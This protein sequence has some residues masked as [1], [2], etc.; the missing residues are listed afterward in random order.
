MLGIFLNPNGIKCIGR[1]QAFCTRPRPNHASS[2]TYTGS[3]QPLLTRDKQGKGLRHNVA[4]TPSLPSSPITRSHPLLRIFY[5][6]SFTSL[7]ISPTSPFHPHLST[8][9]FSPPQLRLLAGSQP[10]TIASHHSLTSST[11]RDSLQSLPPLPLCSSAA[12][13]TSPSPATGNKFREPLQSTQQQPS[14]F[15]GPSS[16]PSVPSVGTPF[17]NLCGVP[18]SAV[19]FKSVIGPACQATTITLPHFPQFP[20]P[21][22]ISAPSAANQTSPSPATGNKFREP[23]QST[24]QQPSSLRVRLPLLP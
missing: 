7:P 1:C 12:N 18:A 3:E 17:W 15:S 4:E 24:Q 22:S 20:R 23:L 13:R 11:F 14:S 2:I 5:P 8:F 21:S 10:F 19:Q 16:V 9:P 6:Q